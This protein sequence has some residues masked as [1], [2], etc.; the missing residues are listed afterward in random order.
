MDKVSSGRD[1]FGGR[2]ARFYRRSEGARGL[3]L[4]SPTM[5]VLFAALAAPLALLAL[6]SFCS[7][8][9]YALDT[10]LSLGQYTQSFG[11]ASYRALLYRSLAISSLV[12]LIT[13][14]LA[15]PIAYFVA[16]RV[17]RAK[18]VWLILLTIPFWT[19]YLLRVFSWKLI[20]G[21]NGVINSGLMSLG[22]VRQ[23][24]EFLLYNPTAVVV[25]LA[26]AWAPFAILRIYVSLGKIERA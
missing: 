12:T 23:P 16:F 2:L 18:F 4:L 17:G 22:L 24:L 20:L 15:Y 13:V 1:G 11:R 6:Y 3:T 7:Q 10:H 9:G 21:Y 8:N 25:T 5:L 19:S 14:A 26:H